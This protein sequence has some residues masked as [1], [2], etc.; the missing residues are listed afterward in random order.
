M[1]SNGSKPRK[2]KNGPESQGPIG[3]G[4]YEIKQGDCIEAI[5]YEHGL[6]WK[7]VWDDPQNAELR[8]VRG[9]PNV[10]LPGD[11]VF[12]REIELKTEPGITEQRHRF[13]RK[14]VP[15]KLRLR[16]LDEKKQP[17]AGA[18]Y[19]I[20]IDRILRKE[21]LLDGEGILDI[22]IPPDAKDGNLI[23]NPGQDQVKYL[24]MLGHIDPIDTISGIQGR[25]NALGFDCGKVDGIYGPQTR[26]AVRAFQDEYKLKVDGF[27]RGE[28]KKK[29]LEMYGR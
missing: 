21:G 23:V 10:L 11:H 2:E 12:V 16:V 15:C 22:G 29:I 17:L 13:K 8:R 26:V 5:S 7:T 9:D 4:N 18:R 6:F 25:L 27:A 1:M 24:L 19:V 20:E 14:G 3:Q 28:T